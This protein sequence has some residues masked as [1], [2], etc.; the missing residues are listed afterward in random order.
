M[1]NYIKPTI[2]LTANKNSITSG[3]KG[4]LSVALSLSGTDLLTVDKTT[5]E[6]ITVS[7]GTPLKIIDGSATNGG[8]GVG[9]TAGGFIYM[10]NVSSA[11]T[12]NF[13]Y[14]GVDTGSADDLEGSPGSDA[15]RLFTLKVGE[16][17]FFPFDY[18]YDINIDANAA[19]QV[20][21]YWLFDRG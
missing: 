19:S 10:Q 3:N 1:A 8:A 9:G 20:L 18:N 21:E 5:S 16:F 12:T 4:P 11:S 17:A 6:I 14:V 7:N 15:K 13:I 2:T